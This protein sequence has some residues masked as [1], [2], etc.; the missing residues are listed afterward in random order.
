MTP[1]VPRSPA[2]PGARVYLGLYEEPRAFV[3]H[4]PRLCECRRPL[5]SSLGTAPSWICP[6][7]LGRA[8][9]PASPGVI[10]LSLPMSFHCLPPA[11][12]PLTYITLLTIFLMIHSTSPC[13]FCNYLFVVLN[14]FDIFL[15]SSHL[16]AFKISHGSMRLFLFLLFLLLILYFRFHMYIKS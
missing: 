3:S 2:F 12:F 6:E 16:G 4:F 11:F 15:L 10:S 14:P 13:T 1:F 8:P 7:S 5:V 9:F